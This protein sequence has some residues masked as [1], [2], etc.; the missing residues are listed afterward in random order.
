MTVRKLSQIAQALSQPVPTDTV[1][2]VRS[3]TIDQQFTLGQISAT[4]GG[5]LPLL[6]AAT[7]YVRTVPVTVQLSNGSPCV[8]TWFSHGLQVG[9]LVVFSS[10]LDRAAVTLTI[11]SPGVVNYPNHGYANGDPVS[12]DTS[13]ALP[14]GIA[15]NTTYYVTGAT[16]NQFSVSATPGGSAINTSGSQSGTQY[17]WRNNTIPSG[18]IDGAIYV[19]LSGNF[20]PNSFTFSKTIGGAAINTTTTQAG[21][22]VGQTGNDNNNGLAQT[23]TGALMTVG[24]AWALMCGAYNLN[25]QMVTIQL[26]HGTYLGGALNANTSADTDNSQT[27]CSDSD[28]AGQ[29]VFETWLGGGSITILGDVNNPDAVRFVSPTGP[30]IA[31]TKHSGAFTFQGMRLE[32]TGGIANGYDLVLTVGTSTIRFDTINFGPGNS[33]FCVV[34]RCSLISLQGNIQVFPQQTGPGSSSF[35][36]A[37]HTGAIVAGDPST[38]TGINNPTFRAT[39]VTNS[40]STVSLNVLTWLGVWSTTFL[41]QTFDESVIFNVYVP[42]GPGSQ[43]AGQGAAQVEDDS[44]YIEQTNAGNVSFLTGASGCLVDA[45]MTVFTP[46]TGFSRALFNVN[47]NVV[48]V[49]AGTLA[50]GT[51]VLSPNPTSGQQVNIQ[52]T[53]TITGFTLSPS[54]GQ[55]VVGAPAT[56]SANQRIR[57]VYNSNNTTWYVSN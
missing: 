23:R 5:L 49:P 56:L 45:E 9:D 51:I 6:G 55:S 13:G 12:F 32:Y 1:I 34:C 53:Q 24:Q 47:G 38:I 8:A 17:A 40:F 10:S 26:A 15:I 52:T 16:V 50:T 39:I 14:T 48:I 46:T 18:V 35:L 21:R 11:A 30:I 31:N 28:Q 36:E 43:I 57:A 29:P 27:F 22:I 20:G 41:V 37:E 44:R 4:V 25:K 3:G 33:F 7:F 2:G 19:V 54:A 42:G